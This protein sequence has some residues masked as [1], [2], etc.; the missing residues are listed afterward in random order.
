[1]SDQERM[2]RTRLLSGGGEITQLL[3]AH[4]ALVEGL[5]LVPIT[6]L[7]SSEL[8]VTS[9]AE[10]QCPLMASAGTCTLM[11]IPSPPTYA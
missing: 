9:A 2:Q 6:Y 8:H 5:S 1:M 3:R 4:T 11:H 10:V 7:S